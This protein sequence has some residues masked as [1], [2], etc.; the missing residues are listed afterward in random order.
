[1]KLNSG[2]GDESFTYVKDTVFLFSSVLSLERQ[3]FEWPRYGNFKVVFG[4]TITKHV[5]LMF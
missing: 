4:S 1:M 2:K 3:I 5:Q